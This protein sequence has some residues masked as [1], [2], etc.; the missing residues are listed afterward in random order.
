MDIEQIQRCTHDHVDCS[1]NSHA[2]AKEKHG[3]G[4][5]EAQ[6]MLDLFESLGVQTFDMTFTDIEGRKRGYRP[7]QELPAVRRSMN[8]GLI[9][10]CGRCGTNI[11]LRPHSS[12]RA[13][14]VQLDDLDGPALARLKEIPF[15]VLA[16]SPGNHQAWVAVEEASADFA[17][18]LRKGAG[19]DPNASGAT[20][21]AGTF[22]FK[23]KY[24]PDY[25]RVHIVEAVEGR[26]VN[27]A[28][29]ERMGL[30]AAIVAVPRFRKESALG[31]KWP[32]YERCLAGAP[33]AHN[34]D[35]PDTSRADFAWCVI[36]A[37]WGH[38]VTEIAAR[39]LEL[40]AKARE[41]GERYAAG[42]AQRAAAAVEQRSTP[43]SAVQCAPAASKLQHTTRVRAE[44]MLLLLSKIPAK[45]SHALVPPLTDPAACTGIGSLAH[46]SG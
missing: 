41:N 10:L 3:A 11:I 5:T 21:V 26:V 2:R 36:A 39:L 28:E 20:R 44:Q 46:A 13:C 19:A 40:S 29:L 8:S 14:L 7:A 12:A 34:S 30:I 22:N 32:S 1:L 6:W 24:S 23:R 4:G 38:S 35:K 18:R 42:T 45:E 16:T 15:L 27:A 43:Q 33:M 37:D 17:R 25:P 31:L 9:E